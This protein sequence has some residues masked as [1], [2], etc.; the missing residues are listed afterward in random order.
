MIVDIDQLTLGKKK[1]VISTTRLTIECDEC[2]SKQWKCTQANHVQRKGRR[3][4]C[5]SCKNKLGVSGMKGKHHSVQTLDKFAG[6]NSGDKNPSKRPEVRTKIS[7]KS[8]GRPCHWKGKKRPEHSK[9]MSEI[10]KDVWS[11]D[12]TY[13]RTLIQSQRKQHS[14]LH[15]DVK[16]WLE[17]NNIIGFVSEQPVLDT[18]FIADELQ[19]ERKLIIEINGDYWHCNPMFFKKDDYVIRLGKK[20]K[21]G[22]IWG[23]DIMRKK[24]LQKLGYSIFIIWEQAFKYNAD[25]LIIEIK[26]FINA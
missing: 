17:N 20:K 7:A 16:K 13:R 25:N 23:Y 24:E 21:V 15:K 4:L 1:Q 2:H 8:K 14:S 6:R 9:K 5:Q 11:T 19:Q 26:N 12:N 10:M 22:E 18:M 3:D